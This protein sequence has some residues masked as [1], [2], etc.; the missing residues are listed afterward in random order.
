MA[1]SAARSPNLALDSPFMEWVVFLRRA[2]ASGYD[3]LVR[4]ATHWG[5][6]ALVLAFIGVPT[7]IGL[8]DFERWWWSLLGVAFVV[9]FLFSVGAYR[10]WVS[11]ERRLRELANPSADIADHRAVSV[12]I[13]RDPTWRNFNWEAYILE[14]HVAIT[15]QTDSDIEIQG[16]TLTYE[17][18][19]G[20]IVGNTDVRRELERTKRSRPQL[21]RHIIVEPGETETG[22]LAAAYPYDPG[23]APA[24]LP[25][26]HIS[27]S[28][29]GDFEALRPPDRRGA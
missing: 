5:A 4:V 8:I 25:R 22:W 1:Q 10:L 24:S 21:L 14:M 11:T 17:G 26:L 3:W 9:V 13:D 15:N 19:M 16:S 23:G 29:Y 2:T 18:G 20:E 12:R 27:V 7:A 6:I 28:G